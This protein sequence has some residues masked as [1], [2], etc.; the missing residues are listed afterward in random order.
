MKRD[1]LLV[2]RAVAVRILKLSLRTF[3]R[4]ERDGVLKAKTVGTGAQASTYDLAVLVPRYLHHVQASKPESPRD[5]RDRSQAE[6]NELRLARERQQLLP[7]EEVV[8]AGQAYITATSAKLRSLGPRLVQT[9]A[10]PASGRAAVEGMVEEAIAE[11][12]RWSTALELLR[13]G[14][15]A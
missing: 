1:P 15:D 6:L 8:A 3:E 13:A 5:R 4:L 14:G 12:S 9:G 2:S 7:R 11:M 10:V